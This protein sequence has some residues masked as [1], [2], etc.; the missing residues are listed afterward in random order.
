MLHA[1]AG[2]G[3]ELLPSRPCQQSAPAALVPHG[4]VQRRFQGQCVIGVSAA[5]RQAWGSVRLPRPGQWRSACVRPACSAATRHLRR[6]VGFAS[7]WIRAAGAALT[8]ESIEFQRKGDLAAGRDSW[9]LRGLSTA[10]QGRGLACG[11]QARRV[12]SL[13][14]AFLSL[15]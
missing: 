12:S 1:S 7:E 14:Q 11:S 15:H 13:V 5:L 8:A 2:P 10:G 6:L 9:G 4:P 3:V